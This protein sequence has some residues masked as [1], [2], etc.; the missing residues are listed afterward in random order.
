MNFVERK[1]TFIEAK[2]NHFKSEK[3]RQNRFKLSKFGAREIRFLSSFPRRRARSDERS[4][5]G[6][7]D[8]FFFR[9]RERVRESADER[10]AGAGCVDHFHFFGDWMFRQFFFGFKNMLFFEFN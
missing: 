2:L 1:L 3:K 4:E 6:V 10:V 8:D 7:F 5:F 9:R